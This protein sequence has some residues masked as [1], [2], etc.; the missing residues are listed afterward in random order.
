[1]KTKYETTKYLEKDDAIAMHLNYDYD[2]HY[3][4]VI[5]IAC[6]FIA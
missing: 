3:V 5:W 4:H 2:R 1:M 6:E